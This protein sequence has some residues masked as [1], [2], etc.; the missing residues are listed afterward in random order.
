VTAAATS[1]DDA[2]AL[3]AGASHQ[4][5]AMPSGKQ[6][7]GFFTM[8]FGM[9]MAILDI[10][11]VSSSIGEIQAGLAAS[12]DEISWIQTSYLIAEVVMIP[13]YGYL[14]RLMSTRILFVI[15]S[16]GFAVFSLACAF[17][18]NIESMI[19]FRAFQGFLGGAMIPTAFATTFALFP[20]DKRTGVT[21]LIGLV[22][23]MAPT[24]GPTL[25]GWITQALS[26]HWLFLIN[27]IP[28]FIASFLV[29][30]L[31]DIDKADWSL[32]KTFDRIGLILM[33]VFLGTLEYVFEEGPRKE[34]FA[35]PHMVELAIVCAVSG[36]LFFWR[37][38]TYANP[39]VDLRAFSDRNFAIGCLFSFI[40][41]VGLYG[42]VYLMPLYL[43]QV[44]GLNS[45]QIGEIMFV[46]GAFQFASA[47]IAG[48]LS[49]VLEPR[50]MLALGLATFGTG[51]WMTGQMT[52]DWGFWEFFLPQAVRGLSLMLCFMPINT[53]ALG[54]LPPEKVK[55]ASGLYNLMRNLGGAIGLALLNTI[56]SDQKQLHWNRIAQQVNAGRDSVNIWLEGVAAKLGASVGDA[57]TA[58]MKKLVNIVAREA[59][60]MSMNDAFLA[61]SAVFFLALFLTPLLKK[62][63][64]GAGAGAH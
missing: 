62:A 1:A 50:V 25:G 23:T 15:S 54:T 59:A 39:I 20:A 43:G 24:L 47:P 41:G 60:V 35:D 5:Q 21:I 52:A 40:L 51:V 34:W 13:L 32:L 26:W 53:I 55:N 11:I 17:A 63:Q 30:S 48:A 2:P 42:A 45:L 28:G 33:A 6:I 9:F 16:L 49:R 36:V 57:E 18:W 46:T 14:S 58:A 10:Q 27:V 8:V 4:P 22:A 12:S 37:A 3:P 29:W 64:A 31:L 19:V 38:F 7:L 44:R 56:L 61:M